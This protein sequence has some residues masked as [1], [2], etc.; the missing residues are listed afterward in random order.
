LKAGPR[1]NLL[2]DVNLLG[3]EKSTTLTGAPWLKYDSLIALMGTA[4]RGFLAVES[5][6]I[7]ALDNAGYLRMEMPLFWFQLT[8]SFGSGSGA[9]SGYSLLVSVGTTFYWKTWYSFLDLKRKE[10]PIYVTSLI[11]SFYEY[12]LIYY[13][14]LTWS[15]KPEPKL[16]SGSSFGSSQMFWVLAALQHWR[17][18]KLWHFSK[19]FV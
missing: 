15:Q 6:F 13:L 10:N 12:D 8:K 7:M 17:Q 3:T 4:E 2:I 16:H 9:S 11:C 19:F 1:A 5:D 18:Q 14:S